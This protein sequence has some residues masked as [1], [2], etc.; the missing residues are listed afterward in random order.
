MKKIL[1]T[2][3]SIILSTI[4][5]ATTLNGNVVLCDTISEK[6]DSA[7]LM[8]LLNVWNLRAQA[9][10]A[11]CKGYMDKAIS[12]FE[13]L[14]DINQL[15]DDDRFHFMGAY[16]KMGLYRQYI[17]VFNTIED[18]DSFVD[19]YGEIFSLTASIYNQL[20][21]YDKAIYYYELASHF[22][23]K[24]FMEFAKIYNSIARAYSY[25]EA[26]LMAFIWSEKALTVIADHYQLEKDALIKICHQK[27][28]KSTMPIRSEELD[29]IV[30]W[31]F[32]YKYEAG[33][34][35]F[36]DWMKELKK[37]AKA[38]NMQAVR[39]LNELHSRL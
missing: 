26:K 17:N 23:D 21:E 27:I 25:K 20:E 24:D 39:I 22:P 4:C 3:L 15:N 7:A 35:S 10:D 8:Q 14:W 31:Y 18:Y 11:Y 32:E 36:D 16:A 19:N 9:M 37:I 13:Q 6:T 29:E 12:Y 5:G 38:G 33:Y 1:I 2:L 34:L 28:N 30:F